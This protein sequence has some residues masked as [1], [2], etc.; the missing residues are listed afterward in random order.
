MQDGQPGAGASVEN[1]RHDAGWNSVRE[2]SPRGPESRVFRPTLYIGT[3]WEAGRGVSGKVRADEEIR[4]FA[5]GS[6]MRSRD[7]PAKTKKEAP[8]SQLFCHAQYIYVE[9]YEGDADVQVARE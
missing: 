2:K 4:V 9:T 8:L 7:C 6:G 3:G 5:G 1:Y